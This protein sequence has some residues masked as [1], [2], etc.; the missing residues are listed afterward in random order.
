MIKST[1]PAV[2]VHSVKTPSSTRMWHFIDW[3]P[4]NL[5]ISYVS[6]Q[7]FSSHKHFR[8]LSWTLKRSKIPPM[9]TKPPVC[10]WRNANMLTSQLSSRYV[11]LCHF[12]CRHVLDE[13]YSSEKKKS[14]FL[15]RA[16][17][18]FTLLTPHLSCLLFMQNSFTCPQTEMTLGVVCLA[19]WVLRNGLVSE[20]SDPPN[21]S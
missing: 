11:S 7:T 4:N 21:L 2:K 20:F 15:T 8:R 9:A 14:I 6:S 13:E 10:R 18:L 1:L 5:Y 17:Q 12:Y 16:S 19:V 3:K